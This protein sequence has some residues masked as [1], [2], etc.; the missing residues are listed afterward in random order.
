LDFI[1]Q[2]RQRPVTSPASSIAL[3]T[4]P[5]SATAQARQKLYGPRYDSYYH[6]GLNG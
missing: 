4:E 3:I 2:E 1:P 5:A 6:R